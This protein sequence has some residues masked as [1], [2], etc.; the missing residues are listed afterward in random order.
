MKNS[1]Q[2]I[3]NLQ[4]CR[5]LRDNREN[6]EKQRNSVIQEVRRLTERVGTRKGEISIAESDLSTTLAAP[7]RKIARVS[8][9]LA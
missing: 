8:S 7:S 9:V 4:R 3:E 2:F 5:K 1:E 6:F